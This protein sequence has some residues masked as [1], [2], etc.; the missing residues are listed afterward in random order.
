MVQTLPETAHETCTTVTT[1]TTEQVSTNGYV[2]PPLL[3]KRTLDLP[4]VSSINVDQAVVGTPGG[5]SQTSTPD[6][7]PH[8][9]V[10][11]IIE[12]TLALSTEIVMSKNDEGEEGGDEEDENELDEDDAGDLD[13]E[14]DL[15]VI[16]TANNPDDHNEYQTIKLSGSDSGAARKKSVFIN[17]GFCVSG[18][19]ERRLFKA[20]SVEGAK[21][22]ANKSD[23]SSQRRQSTFQRLF[24]LKL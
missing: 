15:G 17:E 10:T 2:D 9:R 13:I 5:I 8:R 22:R 3:D 21:K 7:I 6:Y 18:T 14:L 20:N 24:K 12:S 11:E 23:A 16:E 19:A 4:M 1:T